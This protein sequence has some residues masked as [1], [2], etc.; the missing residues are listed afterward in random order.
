MSTVSTFISRTP[1]Q[2]IS[3]L[4]VLWIF[5]MGLS[6]LFAQ[7]TPPGSALLLAESFEYAPG[8]ISGRNGGIGFAAAFSGGGRVVANSLGYT[9]SN[10]MVLGAVGNAGAIL[11]GSAATFRLL[12][13]QGRPPGTLDPSG[14]FGVNGSR[15]YLG[16]LIRRTRFVSSPAVGGL[17]LFDGSVEK[18]FL[19]QPYAQDFWGVD[20]H[21]PD[22]IRNSRVRSAT[23][24]HLLIVRLDFM[25]GNET[26][27][28]Y[29]NPPLE[30]EPA[31]PAIGPVQLPDFRFNRMRLFAAGAD[32]TFDELKM[33]STFA[34]VTGIAN[35]PPILLPLSNQVVEAGSQ[36]SFTV[37]A[38]DPDLPSQQLSY[39]L[40][41]AVPG[42]ATLDSTTGLFS[43]TP[44]PDQASQTYPITFKVTDDGAPPL[45]AS[46]TLLITVNP[47]P[48]PPPIMAPNLVTQPESV[49]LRA[50]E[51]VTLRVTAGGTPPLAYQWTKDGAPIPNAVQD[52][53]VLSAATA[54]DGGA[55]AVVVSNAAGSVASRAALVTVLVAPPPPDSDPPG[56]PPANVAF[57]LTDLVFFGQVNAKTTRQPILG[58][59]PGPITIKLNQ[60]VGPDDPT[61]G[62]ATVLLDENGQQTGNGRYYVIRLPRF[63]TGA[64]R[65][66]GDTFVLPGDRIRIFLN[67]EEVHETELAQ[68]LVTDAPSDVRFLSL[69]QEADHSDSDGDGLPDAWERL[70]VGHL[71]RAGGDLIHPDGLR[72]MLAY[73]L[74]LNPNLN[75]ASPMPFLVLESN[76][77]LAYYFRQSTEST[78]LRYEVMAS[79][80][81]GGGG[82]NRVEGLIPQSVAVEGT[83]R[84]LRVIIP[85]GATQPYRFFRLDISR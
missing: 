64:V 54:Q 14:K 22:G 42:G 7:S 56:T 59:L 61:V 62:S 10:G 5:G 83:S 52:S 4:A 39:R 68:V 24:T 49:T 76:G 78:G 70:Y 80:Q 37:S 1:F 84:I 15:I 16:F 2:L 9:D 40:E 34:S 30:T 28:L 18:L 8:G 79:D 69:N 13:S 45:S 58:S 71:S 57:P 72:L 20:L 51:S 23:G 29:V 66:A 46:T 3:L 50:G 77:K 73:A 26:L 43:W 63:Q 67:G 74:G 60:A 17:S 33:G 36:L 31:S 6:P 32:F 41:G 27:R 44:T 25:A 19:G 55:Y 12:S 75:H 82:W 35:S 53:L 47:R 21:T 48:E 38:T 85:G 81:L 65:R 11:D